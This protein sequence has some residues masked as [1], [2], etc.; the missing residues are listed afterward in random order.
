[1]WAELK[2]REK[3]LDK[4]ERK[5]IKKEMDLYEMKEDMKRT[6]GTYFLFRQLYFQYSLDR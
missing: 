6:V 3:A 5:L 2:E 1:M 4:K